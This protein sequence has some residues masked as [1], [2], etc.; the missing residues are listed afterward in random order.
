M[1]QLVLTKK[2]TIR[3]PPRKGPLLHSYLIEVGRSVPNNWDRELF[4]SWADRKAR[5]AQE[6][7]VS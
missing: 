5:L 2:G 7:G 6:R 3:K 4:E 1:T